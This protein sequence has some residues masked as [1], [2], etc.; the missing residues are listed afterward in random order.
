MGEVTDHPTFRQLLLAPLSQGGDGRE[1]RSSG[2]CDCSVEG[3]VVQ[4]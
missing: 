3:N 2:L 1:E 4:V